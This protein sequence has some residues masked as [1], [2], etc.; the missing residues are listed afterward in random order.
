MADASNPHRP[1]PSHLSNLVID[2]LIS[3]VSVRD[4][5]ED[6]LPE[7]ILEAL[8]T[9]AQSASTSSNLQMCSIVVVT[10]ADKKEQISQL[11]DGQRHVAQA[12]LFLV[13]CPDLY[14]L[15]QVCR[16]QNLPFADRYMEMFIQA[17]VDAALCAQNVAVAAE[18]LGLGIC[19]IGSIRNHIKDVAKLLGLPPRTY[20]LVGMTIGYPAKKNPTKPRLPRE[21]ILH[22][23][24][25]DTSGLE[26]GLD[27][28]DEIMA[29]TG[30]YRGRHVESEAAANRKE[31]RLYGW[32]E[33]TARRMSKPH[34]KR[35]DM[36]DSLKQLGWEYD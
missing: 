4:Y 23:E 20:P 27:A 16:R 10:D 31:R 19:M 22:Q 25:Y 24:T 17:T 34:P 3:H 30:I 35:R 26:E 9:A 8:T 12:P 33:H 2:T 29:E 15:E 5:K 7:G 6:P 28:Y 11:C 21:V 14:R 36:F 1:V 18:S 13:F 32:C